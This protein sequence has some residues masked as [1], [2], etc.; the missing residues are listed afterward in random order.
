MT[1]EATCNN[2]MIDNT[3]KSPHLL[4]LIHIILFIKFRLQRK[5]LLI[6]YV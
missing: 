1:T 2:T 3:E 5:D 6:F 4:S